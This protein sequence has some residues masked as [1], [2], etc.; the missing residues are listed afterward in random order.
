MV[1]SPHEKRVQLR[2]ALEAPAIVAAPGASDPITAKLLELAGFSAVH[3][4][5]SVAHRTSGYSDAGILT[6]HEM[7]DRIATMGDVSD[8]PLIA[9]ADTGFGGAVNVVRTMKEY[10]RAGASAVHIEDQL[11]PK[12]PMHMGAEGAFVTDTEM[13]D[14]IRAAVDTRNDND[15][16]VIARCDI[17]DKQQKL[18]R[19]HAC[20]EAGADIGWLSGQDAE[21]T[22]FYASSFGG[23]PSLG[24]L[25]R[26]LTLGE[27]QAAGASCAVL[28]GILQIAALTAQRSLLE[29]LQKNGSV[30]DYL[31]TLP[32]FDEMS[33]FYNQQG[34]DELKRIEG[35]YGGVH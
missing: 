12:R 21:T 26:A 29:E 14:K 17:P 7:I 6:M 22:T 32:H 33:A 5:G 30:V 10:E 20:L 2:A 8:I 1:S 35:E 24:V 19:L 23:K 3:V 34:A 28:P 13:V 31:K 16:L 27:Y 4:S 9:D 25:P 15:F 11:T 18:E